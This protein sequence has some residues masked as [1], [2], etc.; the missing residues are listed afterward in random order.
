MKA[1]LAV[2]QAAQAASDSDGDNNN[3]NNKL[4]KKKN[5]E[6]ELEIKKLPDNPDPLLG[7][8]N[9]SAIAMRRKNLAKSVS[10]DA[11]FINFTRRLATSSA[12]LIPLRAPECPM[13]KTEEENSIIRHIASQGKEYDKFKKYQKVDKLEA[14]YGI[15]LIL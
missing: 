4:K 8:S 9:T 12:L 14:L 7:L 6:K 1:R 2:L 10:L 3:N 13:K 15:F 5:I 11:K